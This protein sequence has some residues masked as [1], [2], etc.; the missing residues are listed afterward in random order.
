MYLSE[1]E[2]KSIIAPYG[3]DRVIEKDHREVGLD[4]W[5]Y[6]FEFEDLKYTLI[7]TDYLGDYEFDIFSHLLKFEGGRLK[8]VLQ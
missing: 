8:F 4:T 1:P 2:R 3:Y 7:T 6:L 5:I